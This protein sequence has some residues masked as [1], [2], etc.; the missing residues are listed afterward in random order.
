M[1]KGAF[2][3]EMEELEESGSH[4]QEMSTPPEAR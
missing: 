1:K 3:F 4:R 2:S